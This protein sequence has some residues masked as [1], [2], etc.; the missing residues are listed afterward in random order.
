MIFP[1]KIG[2]VTV[3]YNSGTV[4]DDFFNTLNTQIYD[5]FIL[6]IIDNKSPDNSLLKSKELAQQVWFETKFIENN[7]NYGVAKGNNQGIEAALADDCKY[8]LL[9]NN[10]VAL[11]P[12][13]IEQLYKGLLET[14]ADMAVPKIYFYGT[15]I[16]WAA[17]GKFNKIK[18]SVKHF[19][20]GKKDD[21]QYDK[22]Y[23]IEY[24]PTCFMLIKK[25]VFSIVGMMD[26]KYF[27]YYDDVDFLFRARMKNIKTVYIYTSVME[28]KESIST[29]KYSDFT[30]YYVSRNK[31]YFIKKFRSYYYFV[32]ILNLIYHYSVRKIKM[33][34][35]KK[36]WKII[37]TALYDGLS[38]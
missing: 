21:G 25:E 12:D 15:N 13:T 6:Y 18:G 9:S 29:G 10:D 17:G 31:I 24:S 3:L 8:V 20:A 11:R 7:D 32:Y 26:E 23:E 35:N 4:L 36:Q 16:I 33:I 22:S 19:G 38:L 30:V 1:E 2:I 28:H 34:N 5:N 37:P 14:E 27:V